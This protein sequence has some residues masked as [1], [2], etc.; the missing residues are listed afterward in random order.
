MSSVP[1]LITLLR[2]SS[3]KPSRALVLVTP[4]L[5]DANKITDAIRGLGVKDR[6][7]QVFTVAIGEWVV[8]WLDPDMEVY[9]ALT[10]DHN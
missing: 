7:P 10:A 4:T 2:N 8:L 6:Q 1:E 3:A 9:S 5:A